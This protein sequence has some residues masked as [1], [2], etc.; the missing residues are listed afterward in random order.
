MQEDLK[1]TAAI[2]QMFWTAMNETDFRSDPFLEL[3]KA[4]SAM[5]STVNFALVGACDGRAGAL[6]KYLF[7]DAFALRDWHGLMMEPVPINFKRLEQ[8]LEESD[9][10]STI[11]DDQILRINAAFSK[12][13]HY[14]VI[15][16]QKTI[17]MRVADLEALAR[18]KDIDDVE[19]WVKFQVGSVRDIAITKSEWMKT[20]EVPAMN[21]GDIRREL[22]RQKRVYDNMDR[23]GVIDVL[24]VDTEGFDA[25][26]VTNFVSWSKEFSALPM[27]IQYET[28]ILTKYYPEELE[29]LKNF[30]AQNGYQCIAAGADAHCYL[31]V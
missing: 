5:E 15:D 13:T 30:L 29:S 21:P 10:S 1:S 14:D 9:A 22:V 24:Q 7:A 6:E 3:T 20:I 17:K 26:V 12:D 19:H 31:K 2:R 4:A 27:F 16:N 11:I 18:D 8:F 28:K 23:R 25:V